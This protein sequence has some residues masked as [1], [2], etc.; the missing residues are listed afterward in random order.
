MKTMDSS[1]CVRKSGGPARRIR[2]DKEIASKS[3]PT[4]ISPQ[5]ID[6]PE[7]SFTFVVKITISILYYIF[8][9]PAWALQLLPV[10]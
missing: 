1:V 7:N 5:T 3:N 4:K 6:I 2:N 10:A 9:L 8:T